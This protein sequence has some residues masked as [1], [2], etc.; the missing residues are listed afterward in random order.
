MAPAP[1]KDDDE[2]GKATAPVPV[3]APVGAGADGAD[4]ASAPDP[5]PGGNGSNGAVPDV[6]AGAVYGADPAA[7][8]AGAVDG[9]QG[10]KML[11]DEMGKSEK[12]AASAEYQRTFDPATK[13]GAHNSSEKAP[14][15][16]SLQMLA[17]TQSKKFWYEV[18]L[19]NGRKWSRA[20]AT[21]S[22]KKLHRELDRSISA[23]L[24]ES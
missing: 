22:F 1:G 11:A 6:G 5:A 4:A 15:D 12:R 3:P 10:K 8:A 18:W 19:E 13:R 20:K 21:E 7:G 17:G 14:E 23:W 16:V 9:E 24:V 2:P